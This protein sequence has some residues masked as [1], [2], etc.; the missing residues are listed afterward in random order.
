MFSRPS[1]VSMYLGSMSLHSWIKQ[2]QYCPCPCRAQ[3][4]EG[5][6]KH[7]RR[8]WGQ[9]DRNSREPVERLPRARG[10]GG[11]FPPPLG[12]LK[13]P[14]GRG[15]VGWGL[16]WWGGTMGWGGM[17]F[18]SGPRNIHVLGWKAELVRTLGSFKCSLTEKRYSKEPF[19]YPK[20]GTL[21]LK[22][23]WEMRGA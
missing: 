10:Q 19:I 17:P 16:G 1:T 13:R 14:P 18:F 5:E 2:P 20:K 3:K 7:Q 11:S 8:A 15:G 6:G 22:C 4:A 12:E 21:A 23:C 9:T